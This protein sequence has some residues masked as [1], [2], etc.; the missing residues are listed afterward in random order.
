MSILGPDPIW[1]LFPEYIP[2]Y[3][4]LSENCPFSLIDVLCDKLGGRKKKKS[5]SDALHAIHFLIMFS[6]IHCR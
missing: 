6:G 5:K 1:K 3:I 4:S 2:D